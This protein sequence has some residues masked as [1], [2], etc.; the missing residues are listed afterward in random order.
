M[1]YVS[2]FRKYFAKEKTFSFNDA[3]MLLRHLGSSDAYAKLFVHQMIKKGEVKRVGKG[4]YT[5]SNDDAIV[6]FAFSP[7]YYGLE[8][9]LT[10]RKLWTQVSDPVIITKAGAKPGVR[11]AMGR[12]IIV[13]RIASG[14][15]FGYEYL[16]YS[17]IFVPVSNLE[18][19][20][21]DFVY[22]GI[23]I[24]NGEIRKLVRQ[25]DRKRLIS[26][27]KKMGVNPEIFERA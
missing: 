9:A 6:G 22:Y 10:I 18:K 17:G 8:H 27:S 21:V 13:H 1:K 14:A 5:F 11:Q 25:A 4:I 3:L 24:G 15:F 2:E 12:R 20:L 7:F 26:Y 16:K 19:T 23:G